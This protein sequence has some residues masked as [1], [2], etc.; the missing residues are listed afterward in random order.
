MDIVVVS[1]IHGDVENLLTY[2]DKIKELKFDV[3][4]CPGDLT[5]VNTPKGFTQEDIAKLIISE[6]KSLKVPVLAVPGNVDPKNIV[7]IFEDE[8][9]SIHGR[10]KVVKGFG[11]FG[12]G[13]AKTPFETNIEPTEEEL[14]LGL[15]NAYK[16]VERA[17]F[18]VQ[19]THA[20]PHDTRLD[21]IR[22]GI[23]VGSNAVRSFIENHRPILAISAHIHEARGTDK[24]KGTFLINS[25]R[26]PE[27]YLGLV[28][29]DN[30]AI[31]GKV[32]NITE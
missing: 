24:L 21:L 20:P 23:H 25:G 22:S 6:L 2:L 28:S 8:G 12:Y 5:D 26:F 3:V 7:K 9:I 27:G 1:D 18:K 17:K 31:N 15:E 32:L 29:I 13:G 16:D 19:V 10:G 30:G 4:V 11:F 14:K